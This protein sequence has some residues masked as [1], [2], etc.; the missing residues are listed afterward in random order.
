MAS[1]SESGHAKN[2]AN[3]EKLIS[4]C[5]SYGAAYNP[6]NVN[7]R[8]EALNN[9]LTNTRIVLDNVNLALPP[10]SNATA[11]R[12]VAFKSLR[13]FVSRVLNALKATTTTQQVDDNARTLV[14]KI[15]GRRATPKLREEEKK[16]LTEQGKE[17]KEISSS[18]LSFDN[19]L[20]NLDKL[21]KL[22]KT[23]PQYN[24]NE[25]DLT[26]DALTTYFS[27]LQKANKDVL[28]VT[29]PLSNAR[30]ERNN[31]M[32]SELTGLTDIAQ[33]VKV[34]IKSLYGTSSPLYRQ[35]SGL[36]FKRV[37]K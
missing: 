27:G 7:I 33:D 20:E 15:Q 34:Y 25:A 11:A 22:L 2:L 13:S 26:I 16:A 30:I 23:I 24:P 31:L 8:L 6:S 36:E 17:H 10:Y 35:V 37:L 19:R 32:Y 29:P 9:L 14:L 18:Q 12:E 1:T 5:A 21:I 28:A 4:Y 3:F